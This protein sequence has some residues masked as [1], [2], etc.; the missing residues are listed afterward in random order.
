MNQLTK[1]LKEFGQLRENEPL[2]KHVTFKIG[3]PARFFLR[4]SDVEVLPRVFSAAN[5][6]GIDYMML[7][8]GSNMLVRAEGFDGL[9]I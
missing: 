6:V 9:V 4:V 2:S 8:G 3:G 7:G 1:R 5:E